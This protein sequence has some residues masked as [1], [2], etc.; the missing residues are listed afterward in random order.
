MYIQAV[1]NEVKEGM[2]EAYILAAKGFAED[3]GKVDGCKDAGDYVENSADDNYVSIVSSWESIEQ[4][5]SQTALDT[6]L[7]H[8][9]LLRPHFVGNTTSILRLV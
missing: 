6:F 7:N 5:E 3:L 8:K 9:A 1:K 4:M 2:M